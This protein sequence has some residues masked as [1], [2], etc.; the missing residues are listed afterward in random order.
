MEGEGDR[1]ERGVMV[2]EGGGRDLA[3]PKI[4]AWPAVSELLGN[5][6]V[7]KSQL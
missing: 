5:S 2:S 4:L 7:V 3:H 6:T 1:K